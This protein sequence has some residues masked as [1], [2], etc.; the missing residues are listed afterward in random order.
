MY[1]FEE[2]AKRR[3][4]FVRDYLREL[5]ELSNGRGHHQACPAGGLHTGASG[6]LT[7]GEPCWCQKPDMLEGYCQRD[8][9][10]NACGAFPIEPCT[11]STTTNRDGA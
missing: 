1:K 10:G 5:E 7:T 8:Y 9:R 11:T 3:E 2:L 6:V 4:A